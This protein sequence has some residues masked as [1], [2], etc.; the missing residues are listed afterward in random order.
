MREKS[1]KLAAIVAITVL[2]VIAL[3]KGI[4][5]ALLSLAFAAIGGIAGAK[6]KR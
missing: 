2:E 5:G 1:V 6:I 3:W 4:D